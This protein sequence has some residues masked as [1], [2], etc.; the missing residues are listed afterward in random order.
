MGLSTG[1]FTSPHLHDIRERIALNGKPIDPERFV[2]AYDEVL[3]FVEIVDTQSAE[4]GRP[5]MNY[6]QMLVAIAYAAFADAPVTSPSWRSGWEARGTRP[7]SPTARSP[8]SPPSS[9]DHTRML[10]DT[11]EAIADEKSGI[12]KADAVAVMGC[13]SPRSP[14]SWP[15]EPR[16]WVHESPWRATTSAC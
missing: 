4:V 1:R 9:L 13:R 11:V 6:F 16:L 7:T 14:R 10:G 5:R 12:I 15:R 8:W 2:A 3:P